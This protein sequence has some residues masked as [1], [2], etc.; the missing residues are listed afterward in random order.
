ML[1]AKLI[2]MNSINFDY[3]ECGFAEGSM[4]V[5][6]KRDGLSREG[7]GRVAIYKETG[8]VN[9]YTLEC[10]YHGSKRINYI[11]QQIDTR[12]QKIVTETPITDPRSKLYDGKAVFTLEHFADIG[13]SLGIALLDYFEL[14]PIS[15]IPMSM[16]KSIENMRKGIGSSRNLIKVPCSTSL[17]EKRSNSVKRPQT[18]T[19]QQGPKNGCKENNIEKRPVSRI[20]P[21]VQVV[22]KKKNCSKERVKVVPIKTFCFN[23]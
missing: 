5:K 1:F 17:N 7:S 16:Y 4:S 18:K 8:L 12:T 21:V 23:N 15:R 19:S 20:L 3:G 22:K 6:D 14:N 10:N 2:A 9:C 13:R 11:P